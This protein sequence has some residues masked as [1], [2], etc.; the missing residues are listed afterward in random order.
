MRACKPEEAERGKM[1]ANFLT[2]KTKACVVL[3][4][5]GILSFSALL[6]GAAETNAPAPGEPQSATLPLEFNRGHFKVQALANGWNSVLLMLDTGFSISMI[7][8]RLADLLKLRPAGK[9][10]INGIAGQEQADV[11]EGLTLDFAGLPYTPLRVVVLPSDR[12]KRGRRLEGILGAGFFR[13]FIVEI[14][15]QRKTVLLRAPKDYQ[16]SG[17]GEVLAINLRS[18]TP[19]VEA[20]II[21]PGR[22]PVRGSFEIDTGCDGGLCLGHDFVEKNNLLQAAGR[23]QDGERTGVG[24]DAETKVGSVP[25][26][27]LG[28][29]T[30]DKPEAN[31]FL[32]GSPVDRHLAGHIGIEVLRQFKI[33]F[34]YSRRQM[35]LE[36]YSSTP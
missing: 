4:A 22:E 7:D 10:T 3:K 30:V 34:D 29:L 14:D 17:H 5:L 24:G 13:R 31:F 36:P 23:V 16:Y 1:A 35:I 6:S 33:I 9:T 26:V 15:P 32:K 2:V 11:F 28:R 12:K 21:I 18:S 19:V 27:K 8:P 25:Q 20:S